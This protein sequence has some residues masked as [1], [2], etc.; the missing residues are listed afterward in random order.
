MCLSRTRYLQRHYSV[1][2]AEIS[3]Y[4]GGHI[5]DRYERTAACTTHAGLGLRKSACSLLHPTN[6]SIRDGGVK[7]DC[8]KLLWAAAK[9]KTPVKGG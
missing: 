3:G 7:E 6:A 4:V 9:P 2:T 5:H 1:G 8:V